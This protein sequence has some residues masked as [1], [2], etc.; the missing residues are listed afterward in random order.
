MPFKLDT[1][2]YCCSQVLLFFF[3]LEHALSDLAYSE[4]RADAE[5]PD[6]TVG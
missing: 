6:G 1:L 3:R 4:R 5:C 2:R